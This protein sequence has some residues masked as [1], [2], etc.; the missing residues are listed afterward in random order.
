MKISI[1]LKEKKRQKIVMAFCQEFREKQKQVS[2]KNIEYGRIMNL[3]KWL[4]D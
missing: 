3:D 2:I 4:W 1:E